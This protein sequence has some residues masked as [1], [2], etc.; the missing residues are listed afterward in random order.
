MTMKSLKVLLVQLAVAAS[1]LIGKSN[2]I[3]QL[4]SAVVG[5]LDIFLCGQS[6]RKVRKTVL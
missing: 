2:V 5:L 3:T 6:D 1:A 4:A